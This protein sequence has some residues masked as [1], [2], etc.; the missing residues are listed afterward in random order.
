MEHIKYMKNFF[1]FEGGE[2][3]GKTL[4]INLLRETLLKNKIKCIVTREPGGSVVAEKIRKIFVE[5]NE[6]NPYTMLCLILAAR[7][8]N[9][10]KT[11]KTN[12]E[13]N[14]IVICD[15]FLLSTIV[16]QGIINNIEIETIKQLHNLIAKNI[17]PCLTFIFTANPEITIPRVQSKRE[18]NYLDKV[19]FET[20]L[21]INESYKNYKN[22][23]SHNS[24]IIN[25]EEEPFSVYNNMIIE[26]N[27]YMN[28][29]IK[30]FTNNEFDK[31]LN[32]KC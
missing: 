9:I 28:M 11:I 29:Q 22:Y 16:Y 25:A 31:I 10:E 2:G 21:K 17:Q 32:E 20:H 26:F 7:S 12:L 30:P 27:K 8:E 18:S 19:S 1:C 14:I 5:N 13:K 15:R 6:I 3:V 24:V 23:Y 4:Q